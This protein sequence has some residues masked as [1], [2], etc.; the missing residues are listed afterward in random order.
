MAVRRYTFYRSLPNFWM[1][2]YVSAR[3]ITGYSIECRSLLACF[4][5]AYFYLLLR[6]FCSVLSFFCHLFALPA[7]LRFL[8]CVW[9][10]KLNRL[11]S[12]LSQRSPSAG[13][14]AGQRKTFRSLEDEK[15]SSLSC[16]EFEDVKRCLRSREMRNR[17]ECTYIL[18][19]MLLRWCVH[20]KHVQ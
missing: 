8:C 17:F 18:L 5:S 19:A 20:S 16:L 12:Y 3:V 11:R 13:W 1:F 10:S 6:V 15:L 4:Y 7:V 2:T 14:S 9:P